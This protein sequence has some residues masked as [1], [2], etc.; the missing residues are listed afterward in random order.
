MKITKYVLTII[1]KIQ[2]TANLISFSNLKQFLIEIESYH[3]PP[4]CSAPQLLTLPL[5]FLC[6]ELISSLFFFDDD[7]DTYECVFSNTEI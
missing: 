7:E 2:N 5:P 6:L 1:N 4:C 3:F